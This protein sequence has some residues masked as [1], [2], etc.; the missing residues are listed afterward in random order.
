MKRALLL[1][2]SSVPLALAFLG[3]L[4]PA[5]TPP[6]AEAPSVAATSAQDEVTLTLSRTGE[7]LLKLAFPAFDR[8][9]TAV[10]DTRTFS[11]V[12]EQTLRDDLEWAGLFEIQGPAELQVLTLTGDRAHDF[13]QYR[14]LGNELVVTAVLSREADRMVFEGSLYGLTDGKAILGKRYRG[15]LE[16]A[17]QMAHNFADE[18]VSYFGSRRGI[19]R[20]SIAF[21]SDRDQSGRKEI[22]VMDYDGEGQRRLTAH[23][24]TSLSPSWSPDGSGVAYTS[25]WS[26][27]PGLY[28]ADAA[29]GKKS[30]LYNLG[31]FNVTPSF[32]PD[33]SRFAFARSIDGNVEIFSASRTGTEL[34]QLSHSSAIDTNPA[35]SPK[36]N[37]IA[38]TSSRAGG[39]Q[40][41]AMDPEGSNVRRLS[42]TGNHNDNAAWSPDGTKVAYSSMQDGRFQIAIT[43]VATLESRLLTSGS[44]SHEDPSFSPDGRWIAFAWKQGGSTQVWVIDSGTGTILRQL[45]RTGN[46]DSP[47]WSPYPAQ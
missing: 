19:A 17:R 8:T 3:P 35:W 37:E 32:S 46:N 15:G 11:D 20:T 4:A 23:R 28:F 33:G 43:D 12:L 14:S 27:I 6:S 34:R 18:I 13:E 38:F 44:G 29:S 21:A 5:Q 1:M 41:Y 24:S 2:T 40:I 25:F 9:K 39:P 47:S 36:G 16:L 45:T 26:G 10:G 7:A 42:Y 31:R 30:T 22:Y